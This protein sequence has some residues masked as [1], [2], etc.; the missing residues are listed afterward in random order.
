MKF[1]KQLKAWC[2]YYGYTF[3]PEGRINIKLDGKTEEHFVIAGKDV[4]H[5]EITPIELTNEN[6]LF[7]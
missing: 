2:N 4:L 5:N 7:N 3:N 1:K 6:E